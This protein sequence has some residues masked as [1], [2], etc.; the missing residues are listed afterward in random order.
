MSLR[1]NMLIA[2]SAAFI[3]P[4]GT[5]LAERTIGHITGTFTDTVHVF[6]LDHQ[7][8]GQ[9]NASDI[10]NQPLLGKDSKTGL[11]EVQTK[12]GIVLVKPGAVQTDIK[13]AAPPVT[14]CLVMNAGSLDTA[15]GSSN[16]L[17]SNC[18]AR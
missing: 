6:G 16:N 3:L 11:Y 15:A 18:T 10:I 13:G 12:S 1:K 2:L 8:L 9:I 4:V 7:P 17:T 14:P 5:A